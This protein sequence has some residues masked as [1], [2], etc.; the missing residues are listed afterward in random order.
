MFE[1]SFSLRQ[2]SAADLDRIFALETAG[3]VP[4]IVEDRAVFAKRLEVFPE[5][6]LLLTDATGSIQG[7][8]TAEIWSHSEVHYPHEFALGHDVG[9]ALDR[10]GQELYIASY[11]VDPSLKGQGLGRWFFKA[12][13]A[14]MMEHFPRLDTALL[15]VNETWQSAVRIYQGDGYTQTGRLRDFFKPDGLPPQAALVFRKTLKLRQAVQR[16]KGGAEG[17]SE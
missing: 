2:A 10:Q 11:T 17:R 8:F 7:Y 15:I 4:G 5:G 9:A 6:F 14:W 1:K 13:V 3:F 16:R 12:A